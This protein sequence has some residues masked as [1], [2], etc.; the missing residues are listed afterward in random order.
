MLCKICKKKGATIRCYDGC[1]EN[2]HFP[3]LMQEEKIGSVAKKS[4]FRFFCAKHTKSNKVQIYI[5]MN[6]KVTIDDK[7]N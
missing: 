7:I 3:C 1:P 4:K 2:Y 6:L 5:I